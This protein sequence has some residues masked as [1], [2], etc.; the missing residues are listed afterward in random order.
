MNRTNYTKHQSLETFPDVSFHQ[1]W[2]NP[3][4][5]ET[6]EA[7]MPAVLS[8]CVKIVCTF[9]PFRERAQMCLTCKTMF[10]PEKECKYCVM[11]RVLTYTATSLSI[12]SCLGGICGIKRRLRKAKNCIRWFVL[13][14]CPVGGAVVMVI[15]F[16]DS[17]PKPLIYLFKNISSRLK[18]LH[19]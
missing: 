10:R 12:T 11:L 13:H 15:Y 3:A 16:W 8:I 4:S 7:P 1:L 18:C 17:Y 5:T 6:A 9:S 19:E 14:C 2:P